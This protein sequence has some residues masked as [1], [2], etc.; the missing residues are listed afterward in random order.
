MTAEAPAIPPAGVADQGQAE[1]V[2]AG[3]LLAPVHPGEI[4]LEEFLRPLKLGTTRAA[5]RMGV[6]RTRVERLVRGEMGVS[7]DTALRLERLLGAS[8][9]FWMNLQMAYD[10]AVARDRAEPSIAQIQPITEPT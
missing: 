9:E 10:L 2:S 6:P 7:S 1:F 3:G 8:A 4:L 5:L